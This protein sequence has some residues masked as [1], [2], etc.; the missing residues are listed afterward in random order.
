MISSSTKRRGFTL[1]E[2][3]VVIAIIAILIGLLLPAIQKVR[4]SAARSQCSNNLKQIGLGVHNQAGVN[5]GHLPPLC[6]GYNDGP[7]GSIFF[8]VLPYIEQQALY[9]AG[10]YNNGGTNQTNHGVVNGGVLSNQGF[11]PTFYCPSDPTNSL[12]AVRPALGWVG[13]D[14]AANFMLFGTGNNNPR[15]GQYSWTSQYTLATIPAGTS[16]TIAFA[17]KISVLYGNPSGCSDTHPFC[18]GNAWD[19][20]ATQNI[21]TAGVFNYQPYWGNTSFIVG[22]V[23]TT[24]SNSHTMASTY[25]QGAMNVALADGSVRV[26]SS[27]ITSNTWQ[28]ACT[29]ATGNVLGSDW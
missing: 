10:M 29:P 4:E 25:H 12:H 21:N 17:E 9:Q 14:Y 16:N 3:L 23:G 15:S 8:Y 2:L 11:V 22:G 13:G 26:I 27:S 28:T 18:Y 19:Y 6:I 24:L 20:W 7:A 5:D 1:I